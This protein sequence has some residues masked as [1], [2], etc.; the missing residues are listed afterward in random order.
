MKINDEGWVWMKVSELEWRWMKINESEC[1][2]TEEIKMK[3]NEGKWG[4]KKV[5]ER[6]K[7][8][9][10]KVEEAMLQNRS[11]QDVMGNERE[12]GPRG[13]TCSDQINHYCIK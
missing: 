3:V 12:N 9:V 2:C 4:W 7:R 1:K 5:N 10:T 6:E 13:Q 11:L 8:K